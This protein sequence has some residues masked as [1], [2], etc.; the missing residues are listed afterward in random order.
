MERR[1]YTFAGILAVAAV[2]YGAARLGL[3]LAVVNPSASAIWPPTGIALATLILWGYRLWPGVFL[4]AFLA[5]L[6]TQGTVVTSLGVA[7]GN[8]L[9]AFMGAWLVNHYAGGRKVFERA[10]TI[11]LFLLLASLLSTTLSPTIG[12]TTLGLGGFADWNRFG[13]VWFTWW[14]GD[15]VGAMVVAPLIVVWVTHPRQRLD[16]NNA[17]EGL[18]LLLTVALVCQIVFFGKNPFG[19][20]NAPLG[21]LA[22]LPLIWAAYRFEQR[23]ASA[24]SALISVIAIWGTVRGHGPFRQPDPG[25]A[26]LY[27]QAFIGVVSSTGLVLAAVI[28]ERKRAEDGLRSAHAE[29]EVRVNE[30]TAGLTRAN[31]ALQDEIAAHKRAEQALTTSEARFG[32]FL[33]TA[34]DAIVI[35]SRDGRIRRVNAQTEQMFGYA[36]VELEGQPLEMLL[37]RRYRRSHE[38]HR[39]GFFSSPKVRPMGTGLELFGLRKGG[40]EFP[41]EISLS[42]M[43]TQDGPVVCGTIRDVTE[44]KR[45]EA[46]ILKIAEREQRRI[47]QDLHDGLGQQLAGIWCLSDVM[48]KNLS[49][50][51]APDAEAAA[52]IS[53]LL[54]TALNQTRNLARL[55]HPIEA[56]PTGLMSALE[57]MASNVEGLFHIACEFQCDPPVLLRDNTVATQLYRI[58][59]EAVSNAVRHGRPGKLE[60]C[61]SATPEQLTLTVTDDGAGLSAAAHQGQGMGMRIMNYR[62]S[63]IGGSLKFRSGN[64]TG[65]C[66]EC[67]LPAGGLVDMFEEDA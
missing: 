65:T 53:E 6:L 32:N 29:L 24:A 40:A 59:Q 63:K 3:S 35:V 62:A 31:A 54:K 38:G 34:P 67:S 56:E 16:A 42:P 28:S 44:R 49:D 52:K 11:L 14:L 4:G 33:E 12:V 7:S 25:H 39:D 47:A 2:Y 51:S 15:A 22:L 60:I 50:R 55:L 18:A 64:G 30:R 5:N 19:D 36:R 10:P 37:P 26:L 41:V 61:L 46:E 27:L 21:Y 9:E 58:A 57:T 8:S 1:L 17:L 45:L 66:V 43:N 13:A 20:T 48:Q 23:G